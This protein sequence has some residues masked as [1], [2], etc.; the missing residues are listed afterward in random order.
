MIM[1]ARGKQ[2]HLNLG[3]GIQILYEYRFINSG[4]IKADM[5]HTV[6]NISLYMLHFKT[7]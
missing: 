3:K 4:C 6:E 7:Q 5:K 2:S 1:L